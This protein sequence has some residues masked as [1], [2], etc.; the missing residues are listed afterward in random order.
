LSAALPLNFNL[1]QHTHKREIKRIR[2]VS[3]RRPGKSWLKKFIGWLHLWLGLISGIVV[4]IVSITGC[5]FVF[6]KEV[7][8]LTQHDKLF[9]TPPAGMQVQPLSVLQSKAQAALGKDYP[10][11]FITT[12]KEPARAWEFMAFEEGDPKAITIAG[13]VKYYRSVF[14]NPYTG[15][16]TGFTDYTKEFF[17]IVKYLHWSLLLNTPYG[18]P[19]VG[20]STLIFVV[21]LITGLVLWWPKKWNKA[22][23]E[24]SFKIKWKASFKRV[25]YDLHNVLGF[26]SMIIALIIAFT[27][28]VWAF[29]WFETAVYVAASGSTTPPQV[30]TAKSVKPAAAVTGNPVDI[31]FSKAVAQLPDADRIGVTPAFGADGTLNVYG[32]RGKEVYYDHDELQFDQYNG[33]LLSRHNASERNRGEKLIEMNYDIHV[34]A[35]GGMAGKILAFIISL[36]CA[37]LPVTGFLVWW[38]KRNKKPRKAKTPAHTQPALSIQEVKA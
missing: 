19:I 12:Y 11:R 26:Y 8:E 34:G 30:M 14:L 1:V 3:A 33:Q 24:R 20:W 35:I 31:A 13:S 22:T 23:R 15:T 27:G 29:K 7:T 5:I 17:I 9:V 21:L 32:Y 25:N 18:Q 6:Q 37:S 10:V 4:F 36:F 16:V 28:M 38:N 2:K